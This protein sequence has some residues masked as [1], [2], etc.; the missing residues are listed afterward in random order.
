MNSHAS[1]LTFEVVREFFSYDPASGLM[2]WAKRPSHQKTQLLGREVGSVNMYGYRQ[3]IFRGKNLLTHRIAWLYMTGEW[4]QST[5]DHINGDRLDNRFSNLRLGTPS[6]QSQ[7][8][9]VG[10]TEGKHGY[11]GVSWSK[12]NKKWV[13]R[14]RVMDQRHELGSFDSPYEAHL[15]YVDAKKQMH[16]GFS[17]Q[18][19]TS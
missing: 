6:I 19:E 18:G 9:Y 12:R 5:I 8:V 10:P 3:F 17:R 4:P 1:T 11:T 2:V 13:S 15:A 14:I 7:N 16:P